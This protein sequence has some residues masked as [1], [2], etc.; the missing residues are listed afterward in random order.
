MPTLLPA[1][2]S[3]GTTGT[4]SELNVD[5]LT[6]SVHE[7]IA[8][9]VFPR[10][11]KEPVFDAALYRC[12][13]GNVESVV[14]IAAGRLTVAE[15]DPAFALSFAEMVADLGIP[16]GTL[17]R[18]YWVG[19][20]RFMR[21]WIAGS[22]RM[23]EHGEGIVGEQ[24]GDPTSAVFPYVRRVLDLVN[25]RYDNVMKARY[26]SGEE[27]RRDVVDQLLAG[28]VTG[29]SQELDNILAYRL[30]GWHV[31]MVFDTGDNAAVRR[32]VARLG[33][34]TDS[35]G[36]LVV[37]R[38]V[39]RWSAWLGFSKEPDAIR[40]HQ[41]RRA[42]AQ[43]G[44]PVAIGG[45]G[46]GIEGIRQAH[47]EACRAAELR[48]MLADPPECVWYRDVRLEALLLDNVSAAHRFVAAELGALADD[49]ERAHRIRETL[50][51]SLATGSQARAAAELGVHENTVRL[52]VRSAIEVLGEALTARRTELLVA[53]RLRR[54]L[55]LPQDADAGVAAVDATG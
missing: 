48:P 10:H 4:A 7:A 29:Y 44:G 18:A 6:M 5:T 50:L 20:E 27:R 17:E 31:A 49:S 12:V 1:P 24:V 21:E 35:W 51:A 53:L 33:D 9:Q 43:Q 37:P 45:P 15:S 55:G 25:A 23:S 2:S 42:V 3:A 34:Q 41:L 54:A 47:D 30:R 46:A 19:V 38:G 14:D 28:S 11:A 13:G 32:M 39:C 52:R 40:M 22:Q 16:Y 36:S 8:N 26:G